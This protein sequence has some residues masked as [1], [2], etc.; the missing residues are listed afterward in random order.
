M[1]NDEAPMTKTKRLDVGCQE[2]SGCFKRRLTDGNTIVINVLMRSEL[3]MNLAII[4]SRPRR[5]SEDWRAAKTHA[6][7]LSCVERDRRLG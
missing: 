2:M 4:F 1:P 6:R 5:E 3:S 7:D